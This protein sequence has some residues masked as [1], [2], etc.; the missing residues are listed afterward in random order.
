M[1][2][3]CLWPII[4]GNN[5][6]GRPVQSRWQCTDYETEF[7]QDNSIESVPSS[8]TVFEKGAAVE[9]W[10]PFGASDYDC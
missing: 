7:L 6:S 2:A 1:N 9:S 5:N 4:C 10:R 3:F 8:D